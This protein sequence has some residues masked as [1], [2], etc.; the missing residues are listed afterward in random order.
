[1]EN[2]VHDEYVV[3]LKPFKG[4]RITRGIIPLV[5]RKAVQPVGTRATYLQS[6]EHQEQQQPALC[7]EEYS[8]DYQTE[9]SGS[10]PEGVN[11]EWG[12]TE[13]GW[14]PKASE[15]GAPSGWPASRQGVS[16]APSSSQTSAS[17]GLS[18]GFPGDRLAFKALQSWGLPPPSVQRDSK[19]KTFYRISHGPVQGRRT[20]DHPDPPAGKNRLAVR[21]FV[22]PAPLNHVRKPHGRSKPMYLDLQI[23]AGTMSTSSTPLMTHTDGYDSR[24]GKGKVT[25]HLQETFKL[26]TIK[27][28]IPVLPEEMK[29]Q[30]SQRTQTAPN[31]TKPPLFGSGNFPRNYSSNPF[32]DKAANGGSQSK[33]AAAQTSGRSRTHEHGGQLNRTFKLPRTSE[34]TQPPSQGRPARLPTGPVEETTPWP[35]A[36]GSKE[37]KT[38]SKNFSMSG[39]ESGVGNINIPT[40]NLRLRGSNK[41]Y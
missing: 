19:M 37:V 31:S 12:K 29:L 28:A 2:R 16:T 38:G 27:R 33:V 22:Q 15:K 8:V 32:R 36:Q 41:V 24:I 21:D 1:M 11:K 23:L 26:G 5:R 39:I 18:T 25:P 35:R 3:F 40:N 13:A 9:A 6:K 10:K 34:W 30:L 14:R 20:A 7:E 4:G 17:L